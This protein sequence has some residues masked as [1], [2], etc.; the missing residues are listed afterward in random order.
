M[1]LSSM[2]SVATQL[3]AV[4]PITIL[5]FL[6]L[7]LIKDQVSMNRRLMDLLASHSRPRRRR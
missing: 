4:D 5:G 2:L 6:I 3:S 7:V 1:N